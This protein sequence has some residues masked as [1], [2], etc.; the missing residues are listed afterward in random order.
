MNADWLI[1]FG[2][3]HPVVVHFPITLTLLA[4]FCEAVNLVTR[5]NFLSN[6][7]E[8]SL[9][10]SIITS[11]VAIALGWI[12]AGNTHDIPMDAKN[13]LP[14]HRWL[15]VASM[16]TSIC[17]MICLFLSKF[18]NKGWKIGYLPFLTLSGILVSITG[19]L[20]GLM[21]Y[22]VDYFN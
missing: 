22:G 13:L 14:W 7:A 4:C 10:L 20:G 16:V 21:V 15:G 3:F 9:G 19:H 12:L 8:L 2:K 6:C 17:A 5:R 11:L 18:Q 1:Y